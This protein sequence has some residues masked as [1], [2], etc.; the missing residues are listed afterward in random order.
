[1]SVCVRVCGCVRL[2]GSMCVQ[3]WGSGCVRYACVMSHRVRMYEVCVCLCMCTCGSLCVCV[4]A[5]VCAR[6]R[7]CVY[8]KAH[9]FATPHALCIFISSESVLRMRPRSPAGDP[10]AAP[11]A[12]GCQGHV[13]YTCMGRGE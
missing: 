5:Y 2:C 4:F 1:M 3:V 12:Q 6:V 10:G 9:S 13:E 8:H 7:A 11:A